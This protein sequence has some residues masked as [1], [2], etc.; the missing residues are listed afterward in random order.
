MLRK[1]GLIWQIQ[2]ASGT[3]WHNGGTGGYH[4]Y[5]GF[6]KDPPHAVVVLANSANDIDDIGQF[7]LGDRAG[8]KDFEPPKTRKE[9]KIDPRVFDSY[10]GQYKF[11]GVNAT[12][13][14]TREEN[15]LFAQMT[16]QQKFEVFPESETDFF[17]KVVDAQLTFVKDSTGAV[18]Q[19]ILHQNGRDLKLGKVP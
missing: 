8:V 19:L 11:S 4:S 2:T 9:A 17:Y 1:I 3:I 15:R 7:L 18:T 10:V 13:T 12:I 6:K 16:D 5:I 14:V